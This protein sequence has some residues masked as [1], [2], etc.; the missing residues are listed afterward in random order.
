MGRKRRAK[1]SRVRSTSSV[2]ARSPASIMPRSADHAPI[3]HASIRVDIRLSHRRIA[4]SLP[5]TGASRVVPVSRSSGAPRTWSARVESDFD[6][7]ASPAP[8][9]LDAAPHRRDDGGC[10]EVRNLGYRILDER[11][12]V[13][14]RFRGDRSCVVRV[15]TP[16]KNRQGRRLTDRFPG[17]GGAPYRRIG[18]SPP[19]LG[20]SSVVGLECGPDERLCAA[21]LRRAPDL[22][23]GRL[24]LVEGV[25]QP[26]Q[27]GVIA[28]QSAKTEAI[29][30]GARRACD[31]GGNALEGGVHDPVA[32]RGSRETDHPDG[33]L[34][35]VGFAGLVGDRDPDI[36]RKLGA[37][38]MDSEGGQQAHDG[39]RNPRANGRVG[40]VLGRFG[41]GHAIEAAAPRV[42]PS[43]LPRSAAV[44][45]SPDQV[46]QRRV[47]GRTSSRLGLPEGTHVQNCRHSKI[48]AYFLYRALNEHSCVRAVAPFRVSLRLRLLV[49]VRRR[50]IPQAVAREPLDRRFHTPI[51]P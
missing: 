10:G 3:Y 35:N 24:A 17:S 41:V 44:T 47:G 7:N 29:H 42:R 31:P 18:D 20:A 45:G 8:F 48:T 32:Q 25:P 5:R 37:E 19:S 22:V 50:G 21:H 38:F 49:A 11:G 40:V 27:G 51:R 12:D 23:G 36:P 14:H 13:A 1:P 6:F 15:P 2:T 33:Q 9:E 26:L 46:R 4:S 28:D 39:A 16:R 34:R 30:H 43:R